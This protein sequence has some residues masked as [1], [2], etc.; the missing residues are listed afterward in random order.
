MIMNNAVRDW[1]LRYVR[2]AVIV[3][4]VGWLYNINLV[5]TLKLVKYLWTE[6][7]NLDGI[8]IDDFGR[9]ENEILDSM[10]IQSL[11]V[12][13]PFPNWAKQIRLY[14]QYSPETLPF[15]HFGTVCGNHEADIGVIFISGVT[16]LPY[17][18]GGP[19][20]LCTLWWSCMTALLQLVIY[21]TT[22]HSTVDIGWTSEMLHTSCPVAYSVYRH[23][24]LASA[25]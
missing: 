23:L 24:E 25:Y 12:Q 14:L 13:L 11:P 3:P 1:C 17:M 20:M 19:S 6:I 2:K 9:T 10:F 4:I 21:Y 18:P 15:G 22:A 5:E 8:V 7:R 16:G